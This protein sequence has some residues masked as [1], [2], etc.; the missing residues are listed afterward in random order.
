M[1]IASSCAPDRALLFR[2]YTLLPVEGAFLKLLMAKTIVQGQ[3]TPTPSSGRTDTYG[4]DETT[5]QP[6]R[7]AALQRQDT[8]A[9]RC[10]PNNH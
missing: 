10:G 9:R 8:T 2:R 3:D 6:T 7:T 4:N 1:F 5:L